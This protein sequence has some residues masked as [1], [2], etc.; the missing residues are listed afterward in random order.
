MEGMIFNIQKFSLH[1]GPGIRTVV[2]FKGCPLRC[3]W[4]ANP[5]SQRFGAEILRDGKKCAL[6]GACERACPRGAI[7]ILNGFAIDRDACDGCAACVSACPNGALVREGGAADGRGSR[8]GLP[9]GRGFLRGKRG[10]GDALRR[11]G[12]SRSRTSPAPCS[13]GCMKAASTRRSRR[14]GLRGKMRSPALRRRA[15]SC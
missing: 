12:C 3:K 8:A 6:C 5:E 1:D 2:F 15:T 4:C 7:R 11:R 9:S 13:I 14:P 10:R